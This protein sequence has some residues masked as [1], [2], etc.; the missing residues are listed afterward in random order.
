MANPI[1]DTKGWLSKFIDETTLPEELNIN[2]TD[3]GY[4]INIICDTTTG[5]IT[6]M[7]FR[8]RS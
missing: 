1:W 6:S 5:N 4:E 3:A 7:K 8:V 2:P